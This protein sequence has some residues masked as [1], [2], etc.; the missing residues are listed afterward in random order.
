[1]ESI[2][3]IL[4]EKNSFSQEELAQRL[5][6]SRQSYIKYENGTTE[7]PLDIVRKLSLVFDVDYYCIIDNKMPVEPSYSILKSKKQ[8]ES[9]DIRINIPENNIEKF[10]QVFLYVLAKVGAKPNVGQTV[11]YKLLYFIDFDYYE[12]YEKQLMGLSYIKNT[13]GPTPVDFAKLSRQMVKDG[14]IEEVKTE[15]YKREM[16]KYLPL[17]DPDLTML[18]AQELEF[19][20]SELEK[21]SG[22]TA[23]ELSAFS[24]KDIPWIGAKDKEV[25]DYEAVFYRTPETSVR[26]YSE[27]YD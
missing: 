12:L 20:D 21:H 19:I 13:F 23:S 16:T 1:M 5:G 27:D 4:R 2:I 22:K 8:E 15:Y 9:P 11:L 25:L 10:K 17:K 26:A 3:K 24:H 14:L 7:L 6:V 18:S